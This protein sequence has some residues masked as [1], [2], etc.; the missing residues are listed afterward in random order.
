MS[1]KF[2]VLGLL[3][4]KPMS[5]Y[6]IKKNFDGPMSG[7][8]SVS[9]GGLYPALDRLE[10]SRLIE[11][12]VDKE[13]PRNKKIY[14]IT[15]KG[16]KELENWFLA[17]TKSIKCKDEYMLKIFLAKDLSN[18][19]LRNLVNEFIYSK[20]RL[21]RQ[22]ETEVNNSKKKSTHKGIEI[23]TRYSIDTLKSEI[24][25]LKEIVSEYCL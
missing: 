5:G 20:E 22:I 11:G 8:W 24:K 1:L 23:I 14:H 18:N 12:N 17:E 2:A 19:Q 4:I 16:K 25:S 6:S 10:N 3:N 9:Y 13:D 21:L 7:F 15:E